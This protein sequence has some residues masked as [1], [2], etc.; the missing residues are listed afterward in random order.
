DEDVLAG[1]RAH[2]VVAVQADVRGARVV[3]V[4]AAD[5]L[6]DAA[7]AVGE[8]V[9]AA[10]V[11]VDATVRVESR[12]FGAP[13]CEQA[14]PGA[15]SAAAGGRRVPAQVDAQG[16]RERAVLGQRHLVGRRGHTDT[17]E[18]RLAAAR[19]V[20][21][22][23]CRPL[24]LL[25]SNQYCASRG[26][27]GVERGDVLGAWGCGDAEV[28]SGGQGVGQGRGQEE[29]GSAMAVRYEE[30]WRASLIGLTIDH[31]TM[32]SRPTRKEP[33]R[34][35]PLPSSKMP[36][37]RATSPCGQKSESSGKPKSSCSA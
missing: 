22:G 13:R 34:A 4:A 25:M 21:A 26:G 6:D 12:G 19:P 28:W 36:Y 3:P 33:R 27:A 14:A 11:E 23:H 16:A 8:L 17:A 1:G 35:Q 31:C 5:G 20:D 18:R 24:Y 2:A 10:E 7:L 32:P 15:A 37:A 9:E 29:V 30:S